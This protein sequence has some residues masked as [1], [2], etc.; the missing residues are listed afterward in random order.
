M[1][2]HTRNEQSEEHMEHPQ[3]KQG[4]LDHAQVAEP[5]GYR[6]ATTSQIEA[7]RGANVFIRE[8]VSRLSAAKRS[9][10]RLP[11]M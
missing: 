6:S 8:S 9:V 3:D 2:G 4:R 5:A 11:G 1:Q 7:V 10:R